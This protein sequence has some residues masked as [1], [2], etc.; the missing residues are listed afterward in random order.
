MYGNCDVS[1]N[2]IIATWQLSNI[3]SDINASAFICS[4]NGLD[5]ETGYLFIT[6]MFFRTNSSGKKGQSHQERTFFKVARCSE[7]VCEK[8]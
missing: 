1:S 2:Q 4:V 5:V 7:S 6:G 8:L 3:G